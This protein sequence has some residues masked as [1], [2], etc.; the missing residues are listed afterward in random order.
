[1]RLKF[2]IFLLFPSVCIAQTLSGIVLDYATK[3]P[4]ETVAIYF[5][6]TTVG[7]TTNEKGEFLITYSEAIQSTLVVS[8]LGYQKTLITDYRTKKNLVIE[9]KPSAVSLDEVIIDFDDG[10]T[11]KQKLFLFKKEFLGTSKYAKSCRVLNE[12]DLVLRFNK[13]NNTLYVSSDVPVRVK[14]NALQYEIA[15]DILDFEASY[16]YTNGDVGSFVLN[17]VLYIGTSFYRDLEKANK[18]R[19]LRN[20]KK[21]YEG[22]VQHFMRALYYKN[23]RKAGYSIFYKR[24]RVNE[25]SYFNVEPVEKSEFKKVTLNKKVSILY[26]EKSQ[27]EMFLE[28]DKFY[29]DVYGNYTPII[30]VYFY[31]ALGDQRVGDT[32][33]SDYGL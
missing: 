21:V 32:L 20:R 16:R 4:L 30:G 9:L 15:F 17:K 5:D 13:K 24:L 25:W 26:N 7:T 22:S 8:Y 3:Q 29:V 19:I 12:N 27:S 6:N 14:N 10:L 28:V 1:M 33:P 11:R 31:G 23:L 2:W 18:K